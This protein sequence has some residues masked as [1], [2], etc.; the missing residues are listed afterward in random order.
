M[1]VNAYFINKVIKNVIL[2]SFDSISECTSIWVVQEITT[3]NIKFSLTSQVT[4]S[5]NFTPIATPLRTTFVKTLH[6]SQPTA[7]CLNCKGVAGYL[8]L[9]VKLQKNASDTA[10]SALLSGR[11]ITICA[12]C[13]ESF[14]YWPKNISK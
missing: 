10:V 11:Q 2:K 5:R 14:F 6:F 12:R 9:N 4:S 7:H 8:N 1:R 3:Q 13:K